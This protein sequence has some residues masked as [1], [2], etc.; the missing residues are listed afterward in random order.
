MRFV[1]P[2]CYGKLNIK[3]GGTAV[4]D[5][6]HSYDRSRFGYYNLLLT[7]T[8]GVHGDN[9]EMIESRRA[10][11]DTGAYS[12]LADKLSE[13]SVQ[14]MTSGGLLLDIGCGE[15][16]YT[17][18]IMT[19]LAAS[20]K[21]AEVLGWLEEF[22]GKMI[23]PTTG[24]P[25]IVWDLPPS[26]WCNEPIL[27]DTEKC[28][29]AKLFGETNAPDI[30]EEMMRGMDALLEKY[31]WVRDG[32]A[33]RGGEDRTIALFCHH[34]LGSALLGYLIGISPV[35]AQHNLF[36]AP[37]SVTTLVS[38]T[39]SNGVSH[40]RATAIGDTSHLYAGGETVS[41]S[42]LYPRFNK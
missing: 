41:E 33:Y 36:L 38:E 40:F 39:D 20:S 23:S 10:F 14:Y 30:Y 35:V 4:C 32:M 22:R 9:R 34:G 2:K 7:S 1:C 5:A 28:F 17:E 19:G 15:G 27:Y 18:K 25:R 24:N 29:S 11:L 16:Y 31:G 26:L 3:E 6:G 42:G 8:G 13:L 21:D 12:R 37:T